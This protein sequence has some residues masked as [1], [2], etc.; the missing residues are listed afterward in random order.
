M[1]VLVGPELV[2]VESET[3][4]L[5]SVRH[6]TWWKMAAS[7]GVVERHGVAEPAD[8]ERRLGELRSDDR[9]TAESAERVRAV[10]RWCSGRGVRVAWG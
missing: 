7:M 2:C 4:P 3:V 8:M 5:A 10:T 9:C 1:D 6:A